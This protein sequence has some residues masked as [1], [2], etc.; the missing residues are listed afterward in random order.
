MQVIERR[1][2]RRVPLSGR[3]D[4]VLFGPDFTK[5]VQIVDISQGGLAFRY[6]DGQKPL[7]GPMELDILWD[8]IDVFLLRL[9]IKAVCDLQI[10]NEFLLGVI[11]LR[12]CGAEFLHLTPEQLSQLEHCM[13]NCSP[14]KVY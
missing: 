1:R 9:R 11:P 12:R 4:A 2:Y 7:D 5:G 14:T 13:E 3:T 10:A 6:V 8:H